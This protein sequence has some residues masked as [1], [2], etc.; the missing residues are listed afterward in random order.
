MYRKL[1]A[2]LTYRLRPRRLATTP[3]VEEPTFHGWRRG[4]CSGQRARARRPPTA[5][6][7]TGH[8]LI[9]TQRGDGLR[10]RVEIRRTTKPARA[11]AVPAPYADCARRSAAGRRRAARADQREYEEHARH[12]AF[13]HYA[14]TARPAALHCCRARHR[15][16]GLNHSSRPNVDASSTR[17]T[18]CGVQHPQHVGAR[19]VERGKVYTT[20]RRL[21]FAHGKPRARRQTA[22][23]RRR[24]SPPRRRRFPA[25]GKCERSRLAS[26]R[27]ETQPIARRH[28]GR[29]LLGP[30]RR[31]AV[32]ASRAQQLSGTCGGGGQP[33]GPCGSRNQARCS[34]APANLGSARATMRRFSGGVRLDA[35]RPWTASG[36]APRAEGSSARALAT[37]AAGRLRSRGPRAA[38]PARGPW[39][40][41]GGRAPVSLR[42]AVAQR[43]GHLALRRRQLQSRR[44][45][46][47]RWRRRSTPLK[48][49]A[50]MSSVRSAGGSARSTSRREGASQSELIC[51]RWRRRARC[52]RAHRSRGAVSRTCR[53]RGPGGGAAR[54]ARRGTS[55]RRARVLA[56]ARRA[57]HGAA[58]LEHHH[59]GA[60]GRARA[61]TPTRPGRN[62]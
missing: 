60:R 11:D 29:L 22:R 32:A 15:L 33:L 44:R 56:A 5:S 20:G 27:S 7:D 12:T 41:G 55:S 10:A 3:G 2:S 52:P 25:S 50:W 46:R 43:V 24:S 38:A 62:R 23:R 61:R 19:D 40:R 21:W 45:A 1:S 18:Q 9:S 31:S 14:R 53:R 54:P 4:R 51:P 16:A 59:A 42:G 6:D 49:R 35:R 36:N 47:R 8:T 28:D 48:K 17:H 34:G 26:L 13:E 37:P 57:R 39:R 30:Y 58:A